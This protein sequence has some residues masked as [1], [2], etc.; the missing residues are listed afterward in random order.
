MTEGP[1]GFPRVTSIGPFTDT[2]ATQEFERDTNSRVV[3]QTD[4]DREIATVEGIDIDNA[5]QVTAKLVVREE[6]EERGERIIDNIREELD[7]ATRDKNVGLIEYWYT[8]EV[9]KIRYV[10]VEQDF[11][12]MG[13]ATTLKLNELD[14]M[15]RQGVEIVYTDIVSEGGYRL[16]K[17]TDFRPIHEAEHL[18]GAESTLHFG[19]RRGVMFKYL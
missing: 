10:E 12:Q 6:V 8:G 18:R 1:F 19:N 5:V 3:A 17:T 2:P 16:A 4:V 15:R 14:Y 11:Q 13:I 7:R 9:A